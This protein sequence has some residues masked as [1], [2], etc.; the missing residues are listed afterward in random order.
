MQSQYSVKPSHLLRVIDCHYS[1]DITNMP[2]NKNKYD[3]TIVPNSKL[4]TELPV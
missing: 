2:V 1:F 4:H 3:F